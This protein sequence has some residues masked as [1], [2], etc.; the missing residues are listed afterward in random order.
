MKIE[1]L[2]TVELDTDKNRFI[3]I[4][5]PFM[6]IFREE[7]KKIFQ[8]IGHESMMIVTNDLLDGCTVGQSKS[9]R[10]GNDVQIDNMQS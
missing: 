3:G 2:S 4:R 8:K 9:R 1:I 6:M 5:I 7:R 10:V